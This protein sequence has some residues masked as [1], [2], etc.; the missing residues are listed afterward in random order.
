MG[1]SDKDARLGSS[2]LKF[3]REPGFFD[4]SRGITFLIAGGFAPFLFLFLHFREVRIDILEINTVAERY[5]VAQTDF[6]FA[7]QEAT[8]ILREESVRDIDKVWRIQDKE[9]RQRRV[10]FENYLLYNQDWRKQAENSTL[11]EML[12]AVSM[13]EDFLMKLRLTDPRT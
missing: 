9:V 7:D 3:A 13:L 8:A 12:R 1:S 2:E 4:R 6:S 5:V 11:E 10:E